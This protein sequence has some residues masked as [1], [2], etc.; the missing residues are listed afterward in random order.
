VLDF[1]PSSTT[2]PLHECNDKLYGR[3]FED[4]AFVP[5]SNSVSAIINAKMKWL[6]LGKKVQIMEV[7]CIVAQDK[8]ILDPHPK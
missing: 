7:S 6:W 4:N 3:P 1:V 5:V 2:L 8:K